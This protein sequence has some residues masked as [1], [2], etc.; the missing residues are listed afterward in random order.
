MPRH[1]PAQ[2]GSG[3]CSSR[4]AFRVGEYVQAGR[5]NGAVERFSIRSV[6]LRHHRR[7]VFT[8]L[9]NLLGAVE[10]MS[11]DWSSPGIGRI[12]VKDAYSWDAPC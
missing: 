12:S 1:R 2:S 5:Y 6:K 7:P 10:N 11:R 4:F 8:V 3:R 9:F